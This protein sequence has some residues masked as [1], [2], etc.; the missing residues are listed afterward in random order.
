MS[1]SVV[2]V[3][4]L[5]SALGLAAVTY[6]IFPGGWS[7]RGRTSYDVAVLIALA[8]STLFYVL[9]GWAFWLWLPRLDVE[10]VRFQRHVSAFG[11][12]AAGLLLALAYSAN[13]PGR[14][15]HPARNVPRKVRSTG[16]V[17]RGV[18]GHGVGLCRRRHRILGGLAEF[19]VSSGDRHHLDSRTAYRHGCGLKPGSSAV[20]WR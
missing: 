13:L 19:K 20:G 10:A 7:S 18:R 17:L 4:F 8:G 15:V 12:A 3:G 6:L 5:A 2:L 14:S 9:F 11:L 1:R 16:P